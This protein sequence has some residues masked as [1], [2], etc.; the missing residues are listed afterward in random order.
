[1]AGA[2]VAVAIAALAGAPMYMP[3]LLAR[4]FFIALGI[5]VGGIATPGTVH[6]MMTWPLSI[7]LIAVG[8]L[9]T[10]VASS[11]Y[12]ISVHGWNGESAMFAAVIAE[13]LT[14]VVMWDGW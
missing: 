11:V 2:M 10:T 9:I 8:M 4:A 5:T 6:G 1:M 14:V 13:L 7:V 3:T 12:L